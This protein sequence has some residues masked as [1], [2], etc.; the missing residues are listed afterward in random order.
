MAFETARE[1]LATTCS[2]GVSEWHA[3]DDIDQLLRRADMALYAAKSGGR[4]RVVDDRA[5]LTV[6]NYDQH[7]TTIRASTRSGPAT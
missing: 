5:G 7:P 2:L 6:L 4:N 3:G 1:T